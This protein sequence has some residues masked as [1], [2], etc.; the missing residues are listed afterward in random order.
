M[1]R[2]GNQSLKSVSPS[3][4]ALGAYVKLSD[5]D[6]F[7]A[8]NN[9]SMTHDDKVADTERCSISYCVLLCGLLSL[10]TEFLESLLQPVTIIRY[11][12]RWGESDSVVI[13][14]SV[15]YIFTKNHHSSYIYSFIYVLKS[16][17]S[18][19]MSEKGWH[20]WNLFF[21]LVFLFSC[22]EVYA[23]PIT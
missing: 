1:V 11:C 10:M 14:C 4:Q 9:L 20:I 5:D 7:H 13:A 16:F 2:G 21:C 17:S 3:P 15:K 18:S 8:L 6:L 12:L 22:F 23:K 19:N